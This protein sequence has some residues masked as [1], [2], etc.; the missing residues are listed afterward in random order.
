MQVLEMAA[1]KL[2]GTFGFTHF[3]LLA[4]STFL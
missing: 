1:A 2:I 4:R 3:I